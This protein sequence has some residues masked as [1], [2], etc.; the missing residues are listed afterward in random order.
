VH[1]RTLT[2]RFVLGIAG[3]AFIRRRRA[4]QAA[5][6]VGARNAE[7]FANDP[8]DPVQGFDEVPELQVT[9]LEVDAQSIDD[10]E[11]EQDLAALESQVDE[12][13]SEDA[14]AVEGT[15]FVAKSGIDVP[16]R[17]AGDLYGAHTPAAIDRS[18]PDD[19]RAATQGQNW[20]E[21][22]ETSAIENGA[23]PD[24]ELD[25]L[26][27]DLVDDDEVFRPPHASSTRDT[28]VADYGSGGQRGL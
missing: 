9:P 8:D 5:R 18:H 6:D 27:D 3:R 16:P 17:D 7:T 15:V 13:A 10:A 26:V 22:L 23:G 2:K 11:A 28:P 14:A 21:A 12:I 24:P 19:G 4:R 1:L 20:I 25:G